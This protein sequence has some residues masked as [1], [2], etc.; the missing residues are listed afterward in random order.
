MNK[1]VIYTTIFGKYDNLLDDMVVP[2]DYDLVCFTDININSK[3]WNIKKEISLY[4]DPVRSAKRFKILSHRFLSK[5]DISVYLDGNISTKVDINS[6]VNKYLDK[7]NAAFYNHLQCN[8]DP[9][10][11]IYREAE[12]INHLF[13]INPSPKKVPKD[14]L[15]I[16]DMQIK[17]YKKM[18]YPHDNG[19]ICGGVILRRHNENDCIKVMEDWWK[20]IKYNSKR[21]Q[22]SF[23]YVAWKNNFKFNYINGDIRTNEIFNFTSHIK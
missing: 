16:I 3:K 7:S 5:Y 18:E 20:E 13:N 10:N 12:A 2:D 11:C 17:K 6:F 22:L 9:R 19:L 1:K 21:D 8:L 15:S 23:N 4:E 14:D